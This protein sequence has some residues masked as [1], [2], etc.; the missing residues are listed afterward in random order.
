MTAFVLVHGAFHGGW[1]WRH[2]AAR[3]R[4]VG[5]EVF[6]PTLTGLGER[7]HLA[8]RETDLETHVQDIVGV[9]DWELSTR[10]DGLADLGY[11]CQDY[12]GESYSDSGLAGADLTALNIPDEDELVAEY[13]KRAG[14]D[15]IDNWTFYIAYNM[16]RSAGIVQGVYKRGL[17]GNASSETALEYKEAA[18]MRSE[19]A[20]SLVETLTSSGSRD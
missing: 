17:D 10:G 5:H 3:L 14:R 1:C 16:F 4:A 20:W 2:V 6:T 11:M 13:C 9:I 18:R 12:H 8:S 19:R 15:S 7:H